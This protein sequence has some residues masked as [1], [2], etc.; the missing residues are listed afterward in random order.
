MWAADYDES[1]AEA[2]ENDCLEPL[3]I[4]LPR[5]SEAEVSEEAVYEEMEL[6]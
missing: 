3:V 5:K 6:V 4:H 2:L 1:V